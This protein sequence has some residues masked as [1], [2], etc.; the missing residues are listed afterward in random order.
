MKKKVPF[1]VLSTAALAATVT[2]PVLAQEAP[3]DQQDT[4]DVEAGFYD[5]ANDTKYTLDEFKQLS[6]TEKIDLLKQGNYIVTKGGEAL[7]A[8]AIV[9]LTNKEINDAIQDASEVNVDWDSVDEAGDLTVE[10]VSAINKTTVKVTFNTEVDS[11]KAE[12][13]TIEGAKVD[14]ATLNED[15]STATLKVSGLDYN[16]D[17]TVAAT[18]VVNGE[19]VN[20]GS[21]DFATPK[22][23]DL[24]TLEVT[25]DGESVTA[26][27]ADNTVVEFKLLDENGNVDENANDVVLALDATFGNL[28][29][30]RVTIQNG[31]G[32]VVLSSEFSTEEVT[33][34]VSAQIIEASSDYKDLI[35]EVVG[36][37]EVTFLPSGAETDVNAVT[38]SDAESNQA[39]RVVLYFDKA[40]SPATFV[41]TTSEGKFVT[42]EVVVAGKDNYDKQ[43]TKSNV[44]I[45]VLQDNDEKDIIGFRPV[46]GNEKAIEVILAKHDTNGDNN[47]LKDNAEVTV[48]AELGTTKNEA[49]F[50][51]TDA[52]EPEV[53]SVTPE[54]LKTLQLKFSEA[55]AEGTFKI[56]GLW[57]EGDEFEVE[58]GDFDA[59]TGIDHRDTAEL[60]LNKDAGTG[61]NEQRY[62]EPGSH[63]LSITNLKDFAGLTDKANISTSQTLTFDIPEDTTAPSATVS[64]ESPEQFRVKFDSEITYT[65]TL[66]DIFTN[67]FKVYDEENDEYVTLDNLKDADGNN[68]FDHAPNFTVDE[69]DNELV[70]ELTEDW[71]KILDGPEDA[72]Y[73]YQ[74]QFDIPADT[75]TNDAN[76]V[77]NKAFTLDLN[78]TDSPLNKAD[79]VS[80]S[81]SSI[82]ETSDDEVFKVTMDEP[83]KLT[84][85]NGDSVDEHPTPSTSQNG[86]LP[87]VQ[88]E[89]QGKDKE[90]NNV[91]IAGTVVDYS[92]DQD[93][94]D[95][96]FDVSTDGKTLQSLVN[97]G[98]SE[99]WKVVVKSISDDIGNTAAT[100]T[101]DFVVAKE[102]AGDG[103]FEIEAKGNGYAHNVVAYD[104]AGAGEQDRI[105]V[106]FT[107]GVVN[108]GGASDLT[109]VS[110]WTLNGKKLTDVASITVDD[111]DGDPDNGYEKVIITFNDSDALKADSNTI[112]VNKS[113][114]SYDGT[115]LTGVYEVVANTVHPNGVFTTQAAAQQAIDDASAG[116]ELTLDLTGAT[117]DISLDDKGKALTINIIGD[118]GSHN[119]TV[120]AG[121]SHVNYYG[122]TTGDVDI[123]DVSGGSF[124]VAKTAKFGKIAFNDQDGGRLVFEDG[125]SGTVE[126]GANAQATL[127]GTFTDVTAEAG[128]ELTLEKDADLTGLKAKGQVTVDAGEGAS[129]TV[130]EGSKENVSTAEEVAQALQ[131]AKEAFNA[132][133]G[134]Y[135]K[136]DYTEATWTAFNTVLE[137]Q[138]EIVKNATAAEEVT[139][140]T[141]K[142]EN[143]AEDLVTKA[144][145]EAQKA[146]TNAVD[147]YENAPL[148]TLAEVEAAEEL[149]T[150]AEAAVAKV[151][152]EEVKSDLNAR[153]T[154]E[155][156]SVSNVKEEI[157]NLISSINTKIQSQSDKF[158]NPIEFKD[159]TKNDLDALNQALPSTEDIGLG[160]LLDDADL[161]DDGTITADEF[162]SFFGGLQ[163]GSVTE[164]D[165]FTATHEAVFNALKNIYPSNNPA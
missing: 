152:N 120:D 135:T 51:L 60:T 136:A 24:W 75:F 5:F 163:E 11:V 161:D 106:T 18:A 97:Q 71:T 72:Y 87:V 114:I 140:A 130:D 165:T 155:K 88:V 66:S 132:E 105:E 139:E 16:T 9:K 22:V 25:T 50:N 21:K 8:S 6:R 102:V 32:Q 119:L 112:A 57:S 113:I 74:F 121:D 150:E 153:I 2:V 34:K 69:H 156:A 41:K 70:V 94:A 52:R 124:V 54:G 47:Q 28:A 117:Q 95:T 162:A 79:N 99:D 159:A 126:I 30:S 37:T 19:E 26:N 29:N 131:E 77:K 138:K 85:P 137:T 20:F 116:D 122:T 7:E 31:V 48:T 144:D 90:G 154:T 38:F 142:V 118:L 123:T 147:A 23:T 14:A 15:K 73:N 108:N 17:Y 158:P 44:D 45:K 133:V 111:V 80:P 39:D 3:A 64:V 42:D 110:N 12:N 92:D 109:A 27:G 129:Y 68:V 104:Y 4:Q 53:T 33:S 146:A 83:V 10:S 36:E 93:G 46:E 157:N 160:T 63:S 86:N 84:K 164:G 115:P 43:V 40:V 82:E 13:F 103:K 148:T 67:N 49:T 149:G 61:Q 1:A 151:T 56:D 58:F 134:K 125:A 98:Y 128:A 96:Q 143:A 107:E 91:V 127:E 100:L 55:V 35:G 81:I 59:K 76:G 145:A 101:K 78:H 89:F 65:G 141:T 62:F